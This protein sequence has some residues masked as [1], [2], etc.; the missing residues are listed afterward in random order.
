MKIDVRHSYDC[1]PERF[2]EMY[3]DE[4]FDA[5][6]RR[7]SAV[8]RELVEERRE[9]EVVVRRL[10]FT[11]ERELPSA[12]AAMIG[13]PRLTYEQENRWDRPAS[14]LLWKVIPSFLPG[15]FDA[16]G[17]FE[18][19]PTATGCEQVITG[20]VKVNVALVGGRIESAICSE[21]VESYAKTAA[22]GREWL[23]E[24]A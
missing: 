20:E 14:T 6:L 17:K 12:M 10:R 11:P 2:W 5:L 15:R 8:Q 1:T 16:A 4:G 22:A 19:R 3:W 24:R 23:R 18:V 13:S 7:A 21:I 9:G